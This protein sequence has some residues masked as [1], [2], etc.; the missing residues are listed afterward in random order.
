MNTKEAV[1]TLIFLGVMFLLVL[2]SA[3]LPLNGY[4]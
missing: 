4:A 2:L 3:F 1:A